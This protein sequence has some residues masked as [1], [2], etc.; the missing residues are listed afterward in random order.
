MSDIFTYEESKWFDSGK[1][2]SWLGD[3]NNNM[4][5]SLNRSGRKI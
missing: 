5:N 2:I 3:G 1:T 4:S